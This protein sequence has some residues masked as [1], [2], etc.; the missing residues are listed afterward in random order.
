[1]WLWEL[2]PPHQSVQTQDLL[3]ADGGIKSVRVDQLIHWLYQDLPCCNLKDT[4][5]EGLEKPN[6]RHTVFVNHCCKRKGP[7][8]DRC[9]QVV[10]KKNCNMWRE[11]HESILKQCQDT[12]ILTLMWYLSKYLDTDTETIPLQK[13]KTSGKVME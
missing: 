12:N 5:I 1:M 11:M 6:P 4:L 10:A 2:C 3:T 8:I 9:I 7:K 13:C